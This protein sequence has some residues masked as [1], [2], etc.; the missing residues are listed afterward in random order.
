MTST[1]KITLSAIIATI[2]IFS[3]APAFA[4]PFTGTITSE[5]EQVIDHRDNTDRR[6]EIVPARRGT[7]P[8]TL[9]LPTTPTT[10]SPTPPGNGG[11]NPVGDVSCFD[12]QLILF[13][14]GFEV[15]DSN[16]V[17]YIYKFRAIAQNVLVEISM[18]SFDGT[19]N[20][21]ILGFAH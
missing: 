20:T 2:A 1:A 13:Q 16:C 11:I 17:W 3:S 6:N 12:G 14:D 18:S 9:V 7:D 10:P 4:G 15:T 5:R 21:K 8:L 19:Y